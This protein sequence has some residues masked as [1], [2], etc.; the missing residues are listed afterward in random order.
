M[1][2][3]QGIFVAMVTPVDE[4]GR[5]DAPAVVKLVRRAMRAGVQGLFPVGSTG[6]GA[7]LSLAD[8]LL[9]LDLVRSECGGG[10]PVV[11]GV[12]DASYDLATRAVTSYREHGASAALVSPPYYY[13]LS[14]REISQFYGRLASDCGLP[15]IVYSIPSLARNVASPAA[16]GALSE[17]DGIIGI[18]DST[19]DLGYLKKVCDALRASGQR[20]VFSVLTGSDDLLLKSLR[21]GADGSVGAAANLVPDMAVGL[22][23]AY[24]DG[25][26]AEAQLVQRRLTSVVE[27]CRLGGS[28]KG[29]KAALGLVGVAGATPVFPRSP[30]TLAEIEQ[31]RD[32]LEA[33]GV[34]LGG[35]ADV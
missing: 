29:W 26:F 33:A 16:V 2:K 14:D 35:A 24:R 9:V 34:R 11:P 31:L 18:K 30:L 27:A 13:P 25:R 20:S 3:L 15:V 17:L 1:S 19:K 23:R 7:A 4:Q 22:Y 8:R 21:L 28:G 12:L 6:E 32:A 10:L 5:V